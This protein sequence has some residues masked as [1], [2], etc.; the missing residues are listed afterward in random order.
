MLA[1]LA[2]EGLKVRI[3]LLDIIV[4]VAQPSTNI[5]TI[6]DIWL[7]NK[8][9]GYTKIWIDTESNSVTIEISRVILL[10][11]FS[12]M[13]L[14]N[15]YIFASAEYNILQRY[16]KWFENNIATLSNVEKVQ[17]LKQVPRSFRIARIFFRPAS[18]AIMAHICLTI[19]TEGLYVLAFVG[20]TDLGDKITP[21]PGT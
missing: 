7:A 10:V 13:F 5:L 11:V 18:L 20:M 12:L 21:Y 14:L 19:Y 15:L 16:Y 2:E 6:V 4:V 8:D 9:D 1:G 17:R 3:Q